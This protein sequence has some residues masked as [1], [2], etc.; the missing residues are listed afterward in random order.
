MHNRTMQRSPAGSTAA[1][2]EKRIRPLFSAYAVPLEQGLFV[3]RHTTED[4]GRPADM[5]HQ[6][7][8]VEIDVH[9]RLPA[10]T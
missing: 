4:L 6:I 7:V 9:V 5:L 10:R 1:K 2:D 8:D 3:A